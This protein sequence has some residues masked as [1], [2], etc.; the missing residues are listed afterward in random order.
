MAYVRLHGRN[1]DNW[2]RED[3]GRNARYDYLYSEDELKPWLQK[4][5][6]IR[7]RAQEIYAITNN[8]YRGQ[9]VVNAF[10]LQAGLGMP[11]P[12]LPKHLVDEYPRLK[13]LFARNEATGAKG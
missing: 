7:K 5:A 8:H 9:A 13:G 12:P 6:S 4:L 1:R 11:V 10:E 3:A 2:F